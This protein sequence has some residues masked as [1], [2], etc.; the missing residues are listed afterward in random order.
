MPLSFTEIA[1]V[2]GR[3]LLPTVVRRIM[4]DV[5]ERRHRFEYG[6]KEELLKYLEEE[7]R[8]EREKNTVLA[9]TYQISEKAECQVCKSPVTVSE[10]ICCSKCGI[11][12]HPDCFDMMRSCSIFGCGGGR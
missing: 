11:P 9:S 1:S 8:K 2:L 7:V 3:F 12:Y 6:R 4:G 10:A 5:E